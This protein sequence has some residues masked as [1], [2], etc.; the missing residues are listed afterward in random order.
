MS[1]LYG[2]ARGSWVQYATTSC[3]SHVKNLPG[4][5]RH[6]G[7]IR[8]SENRLDLFREPLRIRFRALEELSHFLDKAIFLVSIILENRVY[9]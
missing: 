4:I 3:L 6:A 9:L 2:I 1:V 8:L 5:A 7:R